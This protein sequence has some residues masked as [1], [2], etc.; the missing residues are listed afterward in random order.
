M[1]DG[2]I[3]LGFVFAFVAIWSCFSWYFSIFQITHFAAGSAARWILAL[4]PP[5]AG[6]FL[7]TVLLTAA[8]ADVREAP[9]YIA[10]YMIMG[11]AWVGGLSLWAIPFCGLGVRD[12]VLERSNR[13]AL[14]ACA[15]AVLALTF[16]FSGGNVGDG[17]GVEAVIASSGLATL[18]LF[19][20]WW[21]LHI[22]CG[23]RITDAVTIDRE[24]HAGI[25][26]AGYLIGA[27]AI[28]GFSVAGDWVEERLIPDFV[29]QAW[30]TLLILV[31]A[32]IFERVWPVSRGRVASLLVALGC[33][34][35]G[36][37]YC[38]VRITL[39]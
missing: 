14:W 34:A 9:E 38:L 24:D 7:L 5:A 31:A 35:F 29:R 8:S 6:A 26:L 21:T 10:Y 39:P 23:G 12:D 2:E 20:F 1:S 36:I 4:L 30:P 15:G 33:T 37:G 17:P 22:A 18:G 3:F 19:A 16:C 11:C 32:V 13:A 28:L 25:R 27:G